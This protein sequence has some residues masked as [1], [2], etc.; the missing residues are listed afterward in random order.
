MAE[1]T[2]VITMDN[3]FAYLE[4][5]RLPAELEAKGLG[6]WVRSAIADLRNGNPDKA[7]DILVGV[8]SIYTMEEWVRDEEKIQR[9]KTLLEFLEEQF[10]RKGYYSHNFD[11][12]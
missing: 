1:Q 2:S 4:G 3:V 5:K 11:D 10:G 8:C 6:W 9:A 7:F 12:R